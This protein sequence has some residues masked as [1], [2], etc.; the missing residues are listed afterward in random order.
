M[1][2]ATQTATARGGGAGDNLLKG[3]D[4]PAGTTKITIVCIDVREAP[5]EFSSPLIMEI[6]PVY[7]KTNWAL[8]KTNIKALVTLI[9]DDYEK[10][11]GHE[12]ELTKHV[13]RNPQTKQEAWSLSVTKATKLRRKVVK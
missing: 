12:I 9:D 1:P 10:W 5:E 3:S 11:A 2:S 13:G 8:N 7:D 6:E 4:L